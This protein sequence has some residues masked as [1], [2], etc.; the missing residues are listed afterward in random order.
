MTD[1]GGTW[2]TDSQGPVHSGPGGQYNY[3]TYLVGAAGR[4]PDAGAD[5]LQVA[6]EHR[7]ELHR[8][9]VP[10]RNY[11]DAVERIAAPG[12]VVLLDG[13]RGSGRRTAAVMLLHQLRFTEGRFEELAAE[14]SGLD[15]APGDRFFLDL[16]NSTDDEYLTVQRNIASYRAVVQDRGA[17]LVVVLPAGLEYLLDPELVPLAVRLGRPRGGA[18]LGRH[19]RVD[20]IAFE[21]EQLAD[22]GLGELLSR[23]PMRELARLAGMIRR[24]RDSGHYGADFPSW[25][26]EATAAVTN[27][28]G[29]VA[30]QVKTHRT[31]HERALLLTAA[32][33]EGASADAV[34]HGT[35][36]L[37]E[38]L[39]DEQNET[40]RLT[41]PDFG[42]QLE[43]LHIKRSRESRVGFQGLAY[44]GAVRTHF[45]ANFPDLRQDLRDWVGD[46]AGLPGLSADDRRNLV[47]RFAE[48]CLAAGCPEHLC[49]LAERWT[50]SMP[51]KPLRA[52]SAAALERGLSHERYGARFRSQIYDWV[53]APRLSADFARV[54][55]GVCLR[56]MAS[57]HPDQ[58]L[59]R[60]HHLALRRGGDEIGEARV[61]LLELAR[62][63]RRLY[64]L[65]VD[66][67][68]ARLHTRPRP[69]LEL[70]NELAEPTPLPFGPPWPELARSWRTLLTDRTAVNWAHSMRRWLT[71]AQEDERCVPVLDI[72]PAAASGRADVLNRLYVISCDWAQMHTVS[73]ELPRTTRAAIAAQF[74]QKI[75][76]AQDA[77]TI[78]GTPDAPESGEIQ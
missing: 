74:W 63:N 49:T 45:W 41:Q 1:R 7:Q 13:P 11:G 2:V 3:L 17:R 58:A 38:R 34:F 28:T 77:G 16:S 23:S 44:D 66:R 54:L 6:V 25:C 29:E 9:F 60:L 61:A 67:L 76:S 4:P 36:G 21:P 59:V 56:A 73:Q 37:L 70:L 8:R 48:Q 50:C 65:L 46:C 24:A 55:T 52:E 33:L 30:R 35:R 78:D 68:H 53:T 22:P 20:G 72:L 39:G 19:L 51:L 10:P 40:S 18:V 32:M 15:A 62:R 71:A 26:A 5:P 64:R 12:T 42:E 75:D 57:T 31:A 69:N 43:A 47:V 14:E 27:R